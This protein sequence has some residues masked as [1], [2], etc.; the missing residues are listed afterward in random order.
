ME[1]QRSYQMYVFDKID[2]LSQNVFKGLLFVVGDVQFINSQTTSL[3][4]QR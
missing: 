4:Q 2:I 3:D 1:D